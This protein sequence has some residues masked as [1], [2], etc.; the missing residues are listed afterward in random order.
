MP[1]VQGWEVVGCPGVLGWEV[2]GCPWG[3]AGEQPPPD[4]VLI[5]EFSSV[6]LRRF[7]LGC[8]HGVGGGEH[9][10]EHPRYPALLLL[11]CPGVP[12]RCLRCCEP[13]SEVHHPFLSV[14]G[15]GSSLPWHPRLG[16]ERLGDA[17]GMGSVGDPRC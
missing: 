2:V 10:A 5:A 12:A 14:H 11:G 16:A 17:Q 6:G 4:S 15:K 7:P 3:T 9:P 1:G 13:V 8:R